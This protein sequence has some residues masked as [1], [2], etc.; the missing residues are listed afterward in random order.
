MNLGP[1]MISG[2]LLVN[3]AAILLAGAAVSGLKDVLDL[4]TVLLCLVSGF[5]LAF[6]LDADRVAGPA[7]KRFITI[8]FF[9]GAEPPSQ[10]PPGTSES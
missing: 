7:L 6:S 9:G 4:V 3:A 10:S 1:V 8:R 5:L 2:A